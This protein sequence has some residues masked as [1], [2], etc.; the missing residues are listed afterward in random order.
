MALR[1]FGAGYERNVNA[2]EVWW[3]I[4]DSS[5]VNI[6]SVMKSGLRG[7]LREKKG[8]KDVSV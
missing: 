1:L 7:R 6:R 4:C 8:R 5:P 2:G 3:I